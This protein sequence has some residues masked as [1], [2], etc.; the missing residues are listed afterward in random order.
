MGTAYNPAKR[1]VHIDFPTR[2]IQENSWLRQLYTVHIHVDA[3]WDQKTGLIGRARIRNLT[4]EYGQ[5]H[6]KCDLIH[7]ITRRES[8]TN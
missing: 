3:L 7:L 5:T 6:Q 4:Q 8:E 1:T 2:I